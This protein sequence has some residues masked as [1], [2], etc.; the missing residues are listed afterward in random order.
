MK[1]L[2]AGFVVVM[3]YS[4]LNWSPLAAEPVLNETFQAAEIDFATP[5]AALLHFVE[6]VKANDVAAALQAFTINDYADNYDFKASSTR[7][8]AIIPM[9]QPSPDNY[10]MYDDLN[11]IG[12][13][14]RHGSVIRNFCYS[15]GARIPIEQTFRVQSPDD[16]DAFVVSVDPA[17]LAGL[18]V[19]DAYI[20]RYN[21]EKA[22]EIMQGQIGPVGAN[23]A[24]EMFILYQLDGA[25]FAGGLRLLRYGES[26]KIDQLSSP[27]AG[28]VASG[29]VAA[30]SRE[31]FDDTV[32]GLQE[33]GNVTVE[34]AV[35]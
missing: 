12:L 29:A 18:K 7:L 14:A 23:E 33:S 10:P 15:F 24:T 13:L 31:E 25:Y 5:S 35:P 30:T 6:S 17:R 28:T 27:F 11:R 8:G 19:V 1:A 9:I 34:K 22:I 21:S 20:L 26:W 2:Q 16:I 32:L 3:G 4:A